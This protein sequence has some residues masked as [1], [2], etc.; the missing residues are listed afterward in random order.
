[1]DTESDSKR[2]SEESATSGFSQFNLDPA[3]IKGLNQ[4]DYK[5]PT[6]IQ[7]Q[8]I[9]LILE[10]KDLIALAHTGSG[11]TAACAIPICQRVDPSRPQVQALIIVPTRELAL[12]YATD[13]QK[14]GRYKGVKT[15]AI[16]GGEDAA[17][18]QS[19]LK[20]GVQ[21]LVATPG[22]LIDFIYSRQIDLSHVETLILDEADEMLSMGFYDDLEFII[23]CLVHEHQTLLFS[24]TMPPPIQKLAKSHMNDPHEVNLILE[25]RDPDKI[26]HCFVYC[27]PHHKESELIKQVEQMNPVQ[28]IVFCQ[29]RHQVEKVCQVLQKKFPAVDFLH[30]GMS[31][32]I[33][34]IVTSKFRSGKVR[35]LV[36]TDVVARGL[37]FSKVSHVFIFQLPKDP[38]VF[39]HRS[40]R[41]GRYDKEGLVVSFVTSHDLELLRPIMS[42]LKQ[43]P[44]WLGEPPPEG[45]RPHRPRSGYSRRQ[46]RSPK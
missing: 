9:P 21:V 32:D 35:I 26:K 46:P 43:E 17:L 11:K 3:I 41:T 14:V 38:D 44:N 40:G 5:N 15:F 31:Q 30:A 10:G 20:H 28:A 34:T 39:V 22:R 24:A 2:E 25:V 36:A 12:Q 18:Q 1:M 4:I 16:L 6:T 8:A 37:D 13:T 33:R 29:S 23:Q 27:A 45:S 19:K 42:H 7:A